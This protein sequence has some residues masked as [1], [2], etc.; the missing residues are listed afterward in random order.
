MLGNN[1]YRQVSVKLRVLILITHF[2]ILPL[3]FFMGY[4]SRLDFITARTLY[5]SY[6]AFA[7]NLLTN[8]S[9]VDVLSYKIFFHNA[10]LVISCFVPLLGTLNAIYSAYM[11][12]TVLKAVSMIENVKISVLSHAFTSPIFWLEFL[13]I[14]IASSES[15]VITLL[16]VKNGFNKAAQE[17][18]GVFL[19]LILLSLS[20]L[21]LSATI[22]AIGIL[23]AH[24]AI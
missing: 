16:I 20:L 5:N 10:N 6:K 14:S 12:G 17:E 7:T 13:S 15:L 23:G 11:T 21:L 18:S 2:V 3:A 9:E 1:K 4:S 22:E 8:T 24:I 19:G